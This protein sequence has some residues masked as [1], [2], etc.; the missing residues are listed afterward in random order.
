MSAP[1]GLRLAACVFAALAWLPVPALAQDAPE[2]GYVCEIKGRSVT[3]DW[4]PTDIVVVANGLQARVMDNVLK[5]LDSKP[6]RA[7]VIQ[8]TDQL[9]VV[10]WRVPT[11]V[12]NSSI[13]LTY[14]AAIFRDS[15]AVNLD[16]RG[17][18]LRIKETG[19][20][21]CELADKYL[22]LK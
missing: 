18:Y 22:N 3:R 10:S 2:P 1:Q 8:N 17:T 7:E 13:V 20:G 5:R 6:V 12:D 19:Y 14:R 15:G 4:I 9:L 16:V 21:H 11:R